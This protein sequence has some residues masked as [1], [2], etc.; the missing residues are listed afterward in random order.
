MSSALQGEFQTEAS[1]LLQLHNNLEEI[2]RLGISFRAKHTHQALCRF[3]CE[4]AQLLKPY[5][6][7]DVIAQNALARLNLSGEKA[8]NT[9]AQKLVPKSRIAFDPGLYGTFEIAGQR[10]AYVSLVLC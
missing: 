2:S 9:L 1:G 10:H 5:S 8:F 4:A 6:G 3:V 7:I